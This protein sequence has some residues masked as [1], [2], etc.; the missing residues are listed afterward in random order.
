MATPCSANLST[1][2][3]DC[4]K[5]ADTISAHAFELE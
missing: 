1:G 4:L 2:K 3:Y 5:A